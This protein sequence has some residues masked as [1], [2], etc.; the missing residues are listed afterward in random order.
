MACQTQ[1]LTIEID[2][3]LGDR[4]ACFEERLD[5]RGER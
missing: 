4:F 1:N 3:L 5:R 2:Y